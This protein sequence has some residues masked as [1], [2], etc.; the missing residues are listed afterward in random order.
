MTKPLDA[1]TRVFGFFAAYET[2]RIRTM[3]YNVICDRIRTT[4][5]PWAARRIGSESLFSSTDKG[6]RLAI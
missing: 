4:N 5:A 6:S 3:G 1:E 2:M